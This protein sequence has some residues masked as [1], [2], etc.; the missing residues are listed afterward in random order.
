MLMPQIMG[1]VNVTPDSFSDG[2]LF[3]DVTRARDHA[4]AL[5]GEG[6]DWIDIGGESTRPGAAPV[7]EAE[8]LARIIPVIEAIRA[9]SEVAISVDTSSPGVARAAFAAGAS[10]WNDVRALTRPGA[11]DAAVSLNA[12]V[13]LMHMRGEPGHMQTAPAYDDVVAQVI[14]FLNSRI[15]A[16]EVA[17]LKRTR[18]WVD[19]GIGF[20]KTLAHNIALLQAT[21]RLERDTGCA[22]LIGAS[23]KSMI[24]QID[25]NADTPDKRLPGSLAI[26][27]DAA[28]Q[29]ARVLR[30]HDVAATRQALLV[31]RALAA[32]GG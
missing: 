3:A 25:P 26:A 4:L 11:M 27:L 19:P 15:A 30:V 8:E 24:G 31:A 22:V 14:E 18:L 7:T 1:V 5:A 29:G 28:R 23:R 16:C 6:A 10:L 13:C 21:A 12:R 17:G 20:G 32:G 2:G 9:V